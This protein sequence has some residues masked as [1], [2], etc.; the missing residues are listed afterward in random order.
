MK[1]I[2]PSRL[3]TFA[4]GSVELEDKERE[5]LMR[6]EDCQQVLAVFKKYL[7][8]SSNKSQR[9]RVQADYF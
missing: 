6:C 9:F 4:E 8:D 2:E 3:F 5:H 7:V 1:H